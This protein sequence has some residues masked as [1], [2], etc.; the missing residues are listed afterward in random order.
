MVNTLKQKRE[1]VKR[2]RS[3]TVGCGNGEVRKGVVSIPCWLAAF[4]SSPEP[5]PRHCG[6]LTRA[7]QVS[8][9]NM[10]EKLRC[11]EYDCFF[12]LFICCT[13]FE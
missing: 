2:R 7:L 10:C 9:K 12:L 6:W 3:K 8:W 13:H 5:D 4:S 1:R 11:V